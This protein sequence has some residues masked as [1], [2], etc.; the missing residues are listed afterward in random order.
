MTGSRASA[1][2][3]AGLGTVVG[4][5]SASSSLAGSD[6]I[7]LCPGLTIVT[8]INQPEGDYESIK[9]I[10]SITGREVTVRYSTERK[11]DGTLRNIKVTRITPLV[12]LRN[13]TLYLH[14]F[15][16]RAPVRI[17]GATALGTSSAVLQA[18][19]TT[20]EAELAIIDGVGSASPVD[21]KTHP[22]LYDYQLVDRIRRAGSG[23]VPITVT[24]NEHK[25]TLPAIHARGDFY[26]DKAEFFFLDDEEN[27]IALQYRIGRDAL[28]VVK[29]SYACSPA[30][31]PKTDVPSALERALVDMGRADVYSVYFGFNSDEIREASE[32]TLKL[33][34]ELLSR[35]RDWKLSIVGHTDNIASDAYNLELSKKRAAAVRNALVGRHGVEV[36]RL[37]ADG[38]GEAHPRDTNETLAGRARN[39]R[40]ELVRLP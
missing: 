16:P 34:A 33:I 21:R 7:P 20:G 26:G 31:S 39:R 22:N 8:A 2:L 19:K 10:E 13:A 28:D 5:G 37:S 29:V 6:V 40:V 18:L 23:T 35:H 36:T 1:V 38:A 17:P 4:G 11:I 27:P 25:V 12:D 3:L 30:E 9:T 24:V 32:P 15:D 14:H